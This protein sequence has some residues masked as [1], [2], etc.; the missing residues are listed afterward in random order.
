MTAL[1]KDKPANQF[2]TPDSVDPILL[3]FP[4]AANTTIYGGSMVA[5]NSS[6]YAVP[7]NG[8][9]SSLK[10][11]GIAQRQVA[12]TAAAGFGSAG[13]LTVQVLQGAFGMINGTTAI[14]AGDVGKLAYCV[15]DQTVASNDGAGLRPAAGVIFGIDP[16]SL[17]VYVGLG[18]A[19]LY[20]T[21]SATSNTS[22]FKARGV[23]YA[24]VAALA[25][26]TVAGND[27]ITYAAG[28]V[29]LL[30]NQTTAAECGPYVVGTVATGTAPL[31]R[32]DWWPT[33]S[34]IVQG[35]EISVGGE[36]T[37]F[38]GSQWK[39]LCGKSKIV[40]TDDPLLYPKTCKGTLTLASGTKTLGSAE[41]LFLLA[42]PAASFVA[43]LNTTGGTLT[44]TTGYKC[45]TRTA[46]KSGTAA[47][48][49]LATVAA[50]TI[51]AANNST[52]DWVATNW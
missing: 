10:I 5:T 18:F 39:A 20:S 15:D 23:V 14:T 25:T 8:T 2:G 45:T 41:G 32:V 34:T 12:N 13:Q 35:Q 29:V 38:G 4:V 28:D 24:N 33:G 22:A 16:N 31:T 46:G 19:S 7:A 47:A 1:A 43:F 36:G 52:L 11:W 44:S 9:D 21:P 37:I 42:A 6:G 51:D 17:Q 30:A 3:S 26:F 49:V 27:G 48:T 40:G 50:G